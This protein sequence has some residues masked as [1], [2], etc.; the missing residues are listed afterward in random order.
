[1]R[2]M[3]KDAKTPSVGAAGQTTRVTIDVDVGSEPISGQVN[4]AGK[5]TEMF[6][7]WSAL[8]EFLE[9]AR[10]GVQYSGAKIVAPEHATGGK[11]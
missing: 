8:A 11:P 1:M 10:M 5:R 4:L 3:P 2:P 7:G 6:V 9:E